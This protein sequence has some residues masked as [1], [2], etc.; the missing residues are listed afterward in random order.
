[1]KPKLSPY[2]AITAV[3]W[4]LCIGAIVFGTVFFGGSQSSAL[5][6]ARRSLQDSQ[7]KLAFAQ[8]AQKSET[9]QRT[10]E[11]LVRAQESL[12]TFSCPASAESALIFQVGQLAHTLKLKQFTSRFPDNAPEQILEK[13]ERLSEGWLTIEFVADYLSLAAFVNSI[14]RHEP[15][16][17]VESIHL[18]PSDG[19]DEEA[20]VRMNLSYLIRKG[21]RAKTVAL[22]E[23]AAK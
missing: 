20:S 17:F 5:D 22:A 8:N 18:R 6:Q 3:A 23:T 4:A 2:K 7:E 11:R 13:S 15:V 16:L 14:E 12:N 21:E 1:M 9:K 10:K 19:N